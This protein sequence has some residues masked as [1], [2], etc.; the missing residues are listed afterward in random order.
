MTDLEFKIFI[1]FCLLLVAGTI[2]M[3]FLLHIILSIIRYRKEEKYSANIKYVRFPHKD[4]IVRA[5]PC[6]YISDKLFGFGYEV[7]EGMRIKYNIGEGWER[8]ISVFNSNGNYLSKI[9]YE[10]GDEIYVRDDFDCF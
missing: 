6:D 5:Y 4:K 8:D 7:V 2:V 3:L 9:E 10:R 1:L